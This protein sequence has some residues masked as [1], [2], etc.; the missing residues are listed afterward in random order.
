MAMPS[1]RI[2]VRLQVDATACVSVSLVLPPPP[3]SP[4][5][6]L[7]RRRSQNR[8]LELLRDHLGKGT[9]DTAA[10]RMWASREEH[11]CAARNSREGKTYGCRCKG[12]R[13]KT[14]PELWCGACERFFHVACER[15][16]LSSKELD[17]L[18]DSYLCTE[19][20][21]QQLEAAGVDLLA[22]A[23]TTVRAQLTQRGERGGS[24]RRAVLR[25][26]FTL[27]DQTYRC[28]V[29][30]CC[31]PAGVRVSLLRARVH[32]GAWDPHPHGAVRAQAG[33][34]LVVLPVQ[35]DQVAG[36]RRAVRRLLKLFPQKVPRGGA[37]FVGGGERGVGC[38]RGGA[39]RGVR[40]T[41]ARGRL[42]PDRLARPACSAADC[43]CPADGV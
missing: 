13:V 37:A 30:L 8:Q 20:E 7:K 23:A 36:G 31:S 29:P 32:V 35:G 42:G 41:E 24:G 43:V 21:R 22:P 28:C 1:L 34:G 39:L 6:L 3:L 18:R 26:A 25:H 27:S 15:L 40:A 33:G 11:R 9:R 17:K 10:N 2:G 38:G 14:A 12:V 5:K 16:D 4:T 19:C